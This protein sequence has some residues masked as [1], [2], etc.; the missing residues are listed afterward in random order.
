MK[1]YMSPKTIFKNKLY[2]KFNSKNYENRILQRNVR[3]YQGLMGKVLCEG[4]MIYKYKNYI[5]EAPPKIAKQVFIGIFNPNFHNKVR[6]L[7]NFEI[8]SY[9]DSDN[10][11]LKDNT[12]DTVFI[13]KYQI[14]YFKFLLQS[15]NIFYKIE[16]VTKKRFIN[17]LDTWEKD[18][19]ESLSKKHV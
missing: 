19:L 6:F 10:L 3:I 9:T 7:R 13:N 4:L 12:K 18:I 14:L 15:R 2:E 17:S 8:E 11:S 16:R 5:L 1:D